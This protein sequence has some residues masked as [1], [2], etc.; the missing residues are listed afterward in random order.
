MKE[1]N[2]H[3]QVMKTDGVNDASIR[4]R[5]ISCEA[6]Y[7]E[8]NAFANL[9][10]GDLFEA[11]IVVSGSG[12]HRVIDQDVPCKE[13]D[14]YIIPPE[15]PHGYFV[16][17]ENERLTVRQLLFDISDWFD[18]EI[19]TRGKRRFCFGVF[20]DSQTIACARLNGSMRDRVDVLY[21]AI[22]TEITERQNEWYDAVRG[23]LSNLLINV[24]R[25]MDCAIKN[26]SFGSS[27]DWHVVLKTLKLIEEEYSN[28]ELTL[29]W[30]SERFFISKSHLSRI[31]KSLVGTTFF[32]Y[33]RGVR[34]DHACKLL[35]RNE[36]NVE[37]IVEKCG[38]RDVSS[39]YK[40]FSAYM[41]MTPNEYRQSKCASEEKTHESRKNRIEALLGEISEHLQKGRAKPVKELIQRALD[42]GAEPSR[43][44]DD[45]LLA[46]MKVIGEKFKNNEVYV[47]E[48]LVA[49]RVMNMGTQMLKPYL[50]ARGERVT[51]RVC[52]G[53]VQ[54]D[55]HDI[56]KN[57]VKMMLEGKGLE[58]I[59]LGTDVAPEA[60]VRAVVEDGCRVVCCSALLTTT[61]N[62]MIEV[63]DALK[64]AGVRDQVKVMIGGAP[65]TQEFCDQIGADC[66]TVDAA[67]AADAAAKFFE[68]T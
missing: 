65:V 44:L 25:Y 34:F 52:I 30:I 1:T 13:G 32:E 27:K 18:G 20:N 11:S 48:V 37:E 64:A 50:A 15:T 60:F 51:G 23:Y 54:G 9:Y 43:I 8:K 21:D 57:L 46:G 19:V 66:Y 59:D 53:T 38:L 68:T 56:G 63:M 14:I 12:I 55:L 16:T 7:D 29:E 62:V 28:S 6:V 67:S 45:G 40:N 33:L 36:M 17:E 24:G 2:L 49:A 31:F 5:V 35:E 58:V 3:T 42:E 39:F 47:P 22:E 61:M 41:H 26:V 4:H 10:S